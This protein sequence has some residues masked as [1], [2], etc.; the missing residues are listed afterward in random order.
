M[1]EVIS[2]IMKRRST[3]SF[4]PKQIEANDLE[5]ILECA[6]NAPSAC[7]MQSWHFTVVQDPQTIAYLNRAAK[8]Y[9]AKS[10]HVFLRK[11]SADD[12]DLLYGAPTLII[13]SGNSKG[14]NPVVDCSAAVQNMLICAQSLG[15]GTLWNGLIR[16]AFKTKSCKRHAKDTQRVQCILRYR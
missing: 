15:L 16:E 12:I 5:A 2:A 10:E 4:Q 8:K 11:Y 14:V 13:V 7:N 3:R 6:V 1:N 9:I